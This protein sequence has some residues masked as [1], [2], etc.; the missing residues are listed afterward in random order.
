MVLLKVVEEAT[1]EQRKRI[2]IKCLVACNLKQSSTE[3]HLRENGE[4]SL[5]ADIRKKSQ[6]QTLD[7]QFKGHD[8]FF[9]VIW[10]SIKGFFPQHGI[11]NVF[12]RTLLTEQQW[13]NIY[14]IAS[15]AGLP[16]LNKWLNKNVQSRKPLML[17]M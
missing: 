14:T 17:K 15:C 2:K 12:L 16:L 1:F 13:K 7:S 9:Y 4:I 3:E 8:Y 10:I 6:N 11:S 5:N